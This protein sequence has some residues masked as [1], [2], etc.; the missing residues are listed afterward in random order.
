MAVLKRTA[1]VHGVDTLRTPDGYELAAARQISTDVLAYGDVET[2]IQQLENTSERLND[3]VTAD[4]VYYEI[5][6]IGITPAAS[7]GEFGAG[8]GI[9][10]ILPPDA[11][12]LHLLTG[13]ADL[14]QVRLINDP[15]GA[16]TLELSVDPSNRARFQTDVSRYE[17]F[18]LRLE[19]AD[20]ELIKPLSAPSAPG[21]DPQVIL[22]DGNA[23]LAVQ[24]DDIETAALISA[25]TAGTATAIKLETTSFTIWFEDRSTVTGLDQTARDAAAAAR[26]VADAAAARAA[27]ADG[28]ADDNTAEI[29]T[30]SGRS[31]NNRIEISRNSAAVTQARQEAATAD[32]KA[33]AAQDAIPDRASNTDVD[34]IAATNGDLDGIQ[35]TAQAALDDAD[36]LTVRKMVR[37]LQRVIKTASTTLRG[38]VLLARAE[39]VA[40]SETDTSR[41]LTVARGKDL[42]HRVVPDVTGHGVD[43]TARDAADAAQ[44]TANENRGRIR[45]VRG[46]ALK[47]GDMRIE[48]ALLAS[49]GDLVRSYT[50]HLDSLVGIPDD[51]VKVV[52]SVGT[53]P[54]GRIVIGWDNAWVRSRRTI[55]LPRFNDAALD[56]ARSA[57]WITDA[58]TSVA[59][60]VGFYPVTQPDNGGQQID[61]ALAAY[62]GEIAIGDGLGLG[63]D[64]TRGEKAKLA[65]YR[66]NPP[67]NGAAELVP[68][69]SLETLTRVAYN[70]D[71]ITAGTIAPGTFMIG[72]NARFFSAGQGIFARFSAADADAD[73]FL[74]TDLP[75]SIGN[76]ATVFTSW[77]RGAQGWTA[78][79]DGDFSG[80]G[81]GEAVRFSLGPKLPDAGV[82]LSEIEDFA[83]VGNPAEVPAARTL[84]PLFGAESIPFN[85]ETNP[86][87][88]TASGS[89]ATA[90][91]STVKFGTATSDTDVTD[92]VNTIAGSSFSLLSGD[93]THAT[94]RILVDCTVSGI[95]ID[96]FTNLR[97]VL[98]RLNGAVIATAPLDVD[99]V[100]ENTNVTFSLATLN[101]G[102]VL[103]FALGATVRGRE[104]TTP[105]TLSNLRYQQA[106]DAPAN[107]FIRDIAQKIVNEEADSHEARDA[108]IEKDV[109][110]AGGSM[111]APLSTTALTAP[112]WK[113]AVATHQDQADAQAF[114]IPDSGYVQ[115]VWTGGQAAQTPILHVDYFK[116]PHDAFI[117]TDSAG[118]I[119]YTSNGSRVLLR[120][121]N[122]AG[123]GAY[124]GA[125][126]LNLG[127]GYQ[128]RTWS[129]FPAVSGKVTVL[130]E[131]TVRTLINE[132]VATAATI[133]E[134]TAA[135]LPDAKDQAENTLYVVVG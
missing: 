115:L 28:K 45:S 47:N 72:S 87:D 121:R 127:R 135:E 15:A 25:F 92:E 102:S 90:T 125:S 7:G 14:F 95:A 69:E 9:G 100:S 123:N 46:D 78:R 84:G 85:F 59:F 76:V 93:A 24:L 52:V 33:V 86:R 124:P 8:D 110:S 67:A 126:V 30:V 53:P 2:A 60:Q 98:R 112:Q 38:V 70:A 133:V 96:R 17:T 108:R 88:P 1:R 13:A 118:Q 29:R 105:V 12:P 120:N 117:Y 44:T 40:S 75:A 57:G 21:G 104:Q 49:V 71:S 130:S 99:P 107:P 62:T 122:A 89:K 55:A 63:A 42:I 109:L 58:T 20:F 32:R 41:V 113:A 22:R 66:D 80:I 64:Y 26:M 101:E 23:T 19:T 48:P 4:I 128:W 79:L 116:V 73:A 61:R 65:R 56:G 11:I 5:V 129:E 34:A 132:A 31:E 119:G 39:D 51:A 106:V 36:Y 81:V 54:N 111:P 43:Q 94:A 27:Q 91:D 82:D 97:L 18:R 74:A 10:T 3:L 6:S 16:D 37:A 134:T 68:I 77:T 35:A 131:A 83:K 103:S 114:A 50:L